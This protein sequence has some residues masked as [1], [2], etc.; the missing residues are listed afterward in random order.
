M[1]LLQFGGFK[2]RI[3]EP[4]SS[5]SFPVNPAYTDPTLISNIIR[6]IKE[7]RR[8]G[9]IDKAT[10]MLFHKLANDP[11]ASLRVP[12]GLDAN[13]FI[14]RKLGKVEADITKY[15]RWSDDLY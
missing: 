12:V 14:K 6:G 4:E 9:D 8:F 13:G 11:D 15:E 1:T 7:N 3:L 5:P 2:T 10:S